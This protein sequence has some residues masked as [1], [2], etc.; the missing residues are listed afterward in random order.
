MTIKLAN[1]TLSFP[2]LFQKAQFNGT[3]TKF[4]ATFLLDKVE[5]AAEIEKIKVAIKELIATKLKGMKL[6]ADK[7]CLKDGDDAAY[8]GYEGKFSIKASN[9]DRPL[10]V[11]KDKSMLTE[12]DG[13]LYAGCKVNAIIEL[14]A[15]DNNFGK[16]INCQL[17][18]VQFAA[19][20]TRFGDGVENLKPNAFDAFDVQEIEEDMFAL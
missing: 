5:H 12:A 6:S 10:L 17:S 7:I 16:R 13:V 4:E 8:D 9:R 1:V 20:G 3:D 19:D 14:W 2:H 18:G 11:N 15:Q